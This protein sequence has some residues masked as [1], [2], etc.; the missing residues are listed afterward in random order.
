LE[1]DTTII[2]KIKDISENKPIIMNSS[3]FVQLY[4]QLEKNP[5]TNKFIYH[6][7]D[8]RPELN[9]HFNHKFDNNTKRIWTI[10]PSIYEMKSDLYNYCC[11]YHN[12]DILMIDS[13]KFIGITIDGM[14]LVA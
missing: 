13:N 8:I 1:S 5:S 4:L 2:D 14:Q 7:N 12:N 6:F 11:P 9:S 10:Y 3:M